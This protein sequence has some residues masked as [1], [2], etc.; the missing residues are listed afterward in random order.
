M[1]AKWSCERRREPAVAAPSVQQ[2]VAPRPDDSI[3][4]QDNGYDGEESQRR[5]NEEDVGR[6]PI[7]LQHHVASHQLSDNDGYDAEDSQAGHMTEDGSVE[8]ESTTTGQEPAAAADRNHVAFAPVVQAAVALQ[9]EE[10]PGYLP[11]DRDDHTED[12]VAGVRAER[13]GYQRDESS[14]QRSDEEEEV[15]ETMSGA[16]DVDDAGPDGQENAADESPVRELR[17]PCAGHSSS[18][19]DAA[20]EHTMGRE[21]DV[22]HDDDDDVAHYE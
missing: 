22:A 14:V 2:P 8:F 5:S 9:P 13:A 15:S 17:H 11:S 21:E 4:N 7:N 3:V 19:R 20:N 1:G 16:D 6:R 10:D 12:E 18:D